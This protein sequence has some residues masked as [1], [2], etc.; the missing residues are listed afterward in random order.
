[1]L[2]NNCTWI[3]ARKVLPGGPGLAAVHALLQGPD[4]RPGGVRHSNNHV[5]NLG[6]MYQSYRSLDYNVHLYLKI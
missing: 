6:N 4:A 2:Y 5:G 1:M 3:V